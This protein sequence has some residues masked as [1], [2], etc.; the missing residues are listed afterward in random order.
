MAK[1]VLLLYTSP[2][3][4]EQEAEF[5]D[6][7]DN[8]HKAEVVDRVGPVVGGTRFKQVDLE[9]PDA[10]ARYLCIWELDTDDIPSAAAALGAATPGFTMTAAMDVSQNPPAAHWFTAV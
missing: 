7:Y 6:W 9:N 3:S 1:G 10:P 4:A 2:T 8:T 5:N